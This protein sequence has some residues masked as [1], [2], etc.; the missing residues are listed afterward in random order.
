ML[1]LHGARATPAPAQFRVQ[2]WEGVSG[3]QPFRAL[4][5]VPD[6]AARLI[7]I[8]GKTK[9]YGEVEIKIGS[10]PGAVLRVHFYEWNLKT[11]RHPRDDGRCAIDL[12][13]K[14]DQRDTFHLLSSLNVDD[15]RYIVKSFNQP[16]RFV[17]L[18]WLDPK[19]RTIPMVRLCCQATDGFYGPLG[20]NLFL[21]FAKGLSQ[22][23]VT[24]NFENYSSHT[25]FVDW[26]FSG[27]DVRGYRQFIQLIDPLG[28]DPEGDKYIFWDWNEKA[29]TFQPQEDAKV[30]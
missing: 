16:V 26:Y 20:E 24:Q 18:M 6:Y 28:V 23:P 30:N 3:A 15:E 7:P 17:H 4:K 22:K 19:A 27:I 8:G 10:R 9:F 2:N 29:L 11:S 25:D 14:Q 13:L 1:Q 5:V 12:Y 21:V